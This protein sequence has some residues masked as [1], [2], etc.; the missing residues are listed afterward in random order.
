[1]SEDGVSFTQHKRLLSCLINI[2]FQCDRDAKLEYSILAVEDDGWGCGWGEGI[3][4]L[5]GL[6]WHFSEPKL[7]DQFSPNLQVTH[8][9]F[10]KCSIS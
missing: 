2:S 10:T 6:S 7:L 5:T 3:I 8:K 1:M 9:L 4:S